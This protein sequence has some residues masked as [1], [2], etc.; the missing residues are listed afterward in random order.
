MRLALNW[1]MT[2]RLKADKLEHMKVYLGAD[3]GGFEL[4]EKIK[5]W[6]S[7]KGLEIEDLGADKLESEDD[8]VDYALKVAQAVSTT[9]ARGLLFCRNGFGMMIA[10]N[11]WLGVRCGLA[12]DPKA[13]GRGRSDDDINCLSLPADYLNLDQAKTMIE[14]FLETPFSDQEKY[15]RRIEKLEAIEED[16]CECGGNCGCRSGE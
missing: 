8:Y 16:G 7:L 13:V 14:V 1:D 6:L 10:A 2:N 3:H 5:Q 11:R 12:F 15:I 4:K 9:S